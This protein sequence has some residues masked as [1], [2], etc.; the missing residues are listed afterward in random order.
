MGT[1]GTLGTAIHVFFFFFIIYR[2]SPKSPSP[3]DFHL[4][5][6]AHIL[7]FLQKITPL[8]IVSLNG[9]FRDFRDRY[10]CILLL[11]YY[12]YFHYHKCREIQHNPTQLKEGCREKIRTF[13]STSSS[14]REFFS[15]VPLPPHYLLETFPDA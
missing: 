15:C 3:Q 10:T 13:T 5:F 8:H 6:I 7:L 1:L 2:R 4:F 12:I 11:F 9:D 14:S